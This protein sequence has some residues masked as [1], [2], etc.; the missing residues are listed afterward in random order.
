MTIQKASFIFFLLL[1]GA[2]FGQTNEFG[3]QAGGSFYFGDLNIASSLKSPGPS[4]GIFYRQN[5][6]PFFSWKTAV[7]AT[8]LSFDSKLSTNPYIR[9]QNLNFKSKL[10]ELASQVE[11]NWYRY[12]PDGKKKVFTPY[13]FAGLGMI[14]D[15]PTAT[16]EGKT[17]PLQL[18][19]TESSAY[20]FYHI[21]LPFGVGFKYN[22]AKSFT[23]GFELA[24]RHVYSDY[25]DDVSTTYTNR[26]LPV[27]GLGSTNVAD[28]SLIINPLSHVVGKQRGEQ[29]KDKYLLPMLALS[30]TPIRKRCPYPFSGSDFNR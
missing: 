11:F 13:V 18:E 5:L 28:P 14:L 10:A 24:Y 1:S 27:N 22:F 16:Y 29:F 8:Q 25:I 19:G 9:Y 4:G 2:A 12:Y 30:Y 23:F 26:Y 6:N 17:V 21:I 7:N 20:D 3:M 15:Y